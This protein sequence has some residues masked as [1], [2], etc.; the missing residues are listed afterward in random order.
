MPLKCGVQLAINKKQKY[1]P[2]SDPQLQF[3]L[4]IITKGQKEGYIK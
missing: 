4:L 1:F 2:L 3:L